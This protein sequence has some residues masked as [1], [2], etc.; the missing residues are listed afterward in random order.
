MLAIIFNVVGV[1]M[2]ITMTSIY[3][4]YLGG[5]SNYYNSGFYGMVAGYAILDVF[6][7][8]A[9]LVLACVCHCKMNVVWRKFAATEDGSVGAG[10]LYEP[11]WPASGDPG[12]GAPGGGNMDGQQLMPL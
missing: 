8:T 10:M 9:L 1:L 7:N 2:S 4:R 12:A 5:G 6:L 11:V 3:D